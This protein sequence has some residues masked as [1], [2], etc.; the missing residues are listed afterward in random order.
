MKKKLFLF[1][2]L[3]FLTFKVIAQKN[4]NPGFIVQ[5][6]DTLEGLVSLK[7]LVKSGNEVDFKLPHSSAI[8][9]YTP[10]DIDAYGLAQGD[11]FEAMRIGTG[12]TAQLVFF[13]VL[14]LG[15]T[16]LYSF[17]DA[18]NKVHYY[19]THEGITRELI[20]KKE[21]RVLPSGQKVMF[22]NEV[23]RAT[24]LDLAK[25]CPSLHTALKRV[26]LKQ[27]D[28]TNFIIQFN[29]CQRSDETL[30][31]AQPVKAQVSWGVLIGTSTTSLE[32]KNVPTPVLNQTYTSTLRPTAGLF[33]NTTLPWVNKKLSVQAEVLY[34]RMSFSKHLTE[35]V[36]I[37]QNE[38][39]V[40]IDVHSLKIPVMLRY[41]F[42]IGKI[43]PYLQA[44][45]AYSLVL[46]HKQNVLTTSSTSSGTT[47]V[48][49]R[50]LIETFNPNESRWSY[51]EA[52]RKHAQA[53]FIG[54]GVK[55]PLLPKHPL[56]IET[57]F[58]RGNG[59]SEIPVISTNTKQFSLLMGLAF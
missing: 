53:F 27:K 26:Y 28:L 33:I 58:E 17:R 51:V 32:V 42:F 43:A 55:L 54:G 29:N 7:G 5:K 6:G 13:K 18:D 12:D 49:N 19:V 37:R 44:G 14:V 1:I 2:I 23:Y 35:V 15:N 20:R 46:K 24:L 41:S 8:T 56:M 47:T 40:D 31:V 22:T 11:R 38:Y 21:T 52:F 4:F 25:D 3:P 59:F 39:D 45:I 10:N 34:D 9:T 36:S 57:R 30:Y 16:N 48:E 50:Y